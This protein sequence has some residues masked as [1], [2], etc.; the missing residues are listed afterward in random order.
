MGLQARVTGDETRERGASEIRNASNNNGSLL[1]D[2]HSDEQLQTSEDRF[3]LQGLGV[4]PRSRRLYVKRRFSYPA[5][6][7]ALSLFETL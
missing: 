3:R 6:S 5:K 2:L 7:P 4:W 1:N